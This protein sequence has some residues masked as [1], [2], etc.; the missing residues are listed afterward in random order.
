MIYTT[1]PA[2]KSDIEWLDPFY[3]ELM[4]PYVELTHKWNEV[5]FRESFDFEHTNIIQINNQ[6]IGMLKVEQRDGYTFLGDIQI[7]K[8]FQGRGIGSQIINDLI[9]KSIF[10]GLP[11]RLKVLKGNPAIRLYQRLGFTVANEL[12][13]SYEMEYLI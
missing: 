8:E 2:T 6:N 7:K 1:R 5:K 4:K 9:E 12:D 3:E 10:Q 13:N 11:I